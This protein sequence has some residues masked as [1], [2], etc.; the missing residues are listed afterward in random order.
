MDRFEETERKLNESQKRLRKTGERFDKFR[1]FG[2]RFCLGIGII[3]SILGLALLG[4]AA[5]QITKSE[6][7][8]TIAIVVAGITLAYFV[9]PLIIP[10]RK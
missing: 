3:F 2:M 10:K 5:Y 7:V 9:K 1:S 8:S 6:V 4:I